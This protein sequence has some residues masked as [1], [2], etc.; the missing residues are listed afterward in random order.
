MDEYKRRLLARQAAN[1]KK[2]VLTRK[3]VEV[4]KQRL[5]EGDKVKEIA[6][7][8]QVSEQTITRIRDGKTWSWV[9]VK[10]GEELEAEAAESLRTLQGLLR[11]E[12]GEGQA[13]RQAGQT[14]QKEAALDMARFFLGDR[15]KD[16]GLREKATGPEG[17]VVVRGNPWELTAKPDEGEGGGLAALQRDVGKAKESD[18]L[19][20]ELG[21]G[22]AGQVEG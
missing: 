22:Q 15:A 13:E 16:A 4:V 17:E 19:I 9:E 18:G 7:F 1:E 6:G 12:G 14:D 21:T 8:F 5:L 2:G 11:A 3:D 20:E 10:A